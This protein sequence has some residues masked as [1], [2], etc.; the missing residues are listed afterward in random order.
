MKESEPGISAAALVFPGQR[1]LR[2]QIER[3]FFRERHALENGIDTLLVDLTAYERSNDLVRVTGERLDALLSPDLCAI[4]ALTDGVLAPVFNRGRAVPPALSVDGPLVDAAI[5]RRRPI[6]ARALRGDLE[7]GS[8]DRAVVGQELHD[9]VRTA[10]AYLS[11]V[12]VAP[13]CEKPLWK[14]APHAKLGLV[15]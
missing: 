15:A 6:L 12:L 7:P 2:P 4:Y 9:P 10:R 5:Q 13:P 14:Y 3:I 1:V 11:C 8:A